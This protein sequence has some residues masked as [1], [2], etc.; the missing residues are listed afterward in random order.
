MSKRKTQTAI[1][2]YRAEGFVQ[3]ALVNYLA[4]LGWSP[5]PRRTSSRSTTS[6]GGS[7]SSTSTRAAQS[8]IGS[9]W[10]G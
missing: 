7:S 2:D 3:E 5:A 4:C 1:A 10:S 9:G 6:S 8:S